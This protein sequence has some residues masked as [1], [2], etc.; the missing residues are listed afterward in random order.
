MTSSMRFYLH[1]LIAVICVL[2]GLVGCARDDGAQGARG[3]TPV[4]YV[5]C[6]KA[7]VDCVVQARFRSL[8]DCEDARAMLDAACDRVTQPGQIICNTTAKPVLAE[9]YCVR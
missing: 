6:S 4:R 8:E 5:L 2:T 1:G 3:S 7:S 9:T